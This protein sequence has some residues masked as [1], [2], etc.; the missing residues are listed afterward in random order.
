MQSAKAFIFCSDNED[1]GI[2]PVEA[3]ASGC[4][5]IAYKSG[6]VTE[7]VIDGQTG[8]FFNELTPESCVTALQKFQ[9]LKINPKDCTSRATEFSTPKFKQ[10]IK[11]TAQSIYQPQS[12]ADTTL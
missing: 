9:K 8:V 4:P 11:K 7:T 5:V 1:F 10:K 12:S 3:M 6:G 2:I